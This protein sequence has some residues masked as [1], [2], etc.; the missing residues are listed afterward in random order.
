VLQPEIAQKIT[1]TSILGVQGHS[2]SLMLVHPKNLLPVLVM[3][4]SM[5]EPICN[6]FHSRRTNSGKI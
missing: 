5:S 4:S 6:R 1:K 2:S 3:I